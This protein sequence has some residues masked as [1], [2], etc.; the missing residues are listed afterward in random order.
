MALSNMYEHRLNE[1]ARAM[2]ELR[3]LLDKYPSTRHVRLI[4]GALNALKARRFG[5][6]FAPTPTT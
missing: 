6:A 4:R 2:F 1:P 3:R 5:D